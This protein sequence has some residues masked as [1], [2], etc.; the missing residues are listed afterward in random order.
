L[1]KAGGSVSGDNEGKTNEIAIKF[2][3]IGGLTKMEALQEHPNVK[4]YKKVVEIMEQHYG[5]I[6][7]NDENEEPLPE[8]FVFN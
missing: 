1:L 3:E 7:V 5:L 2:D 6:E 8:Q 4:I